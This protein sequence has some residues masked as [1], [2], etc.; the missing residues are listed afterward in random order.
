MPQLYT[1]QRLFGQPGMFLT[2]LFDPPFI[3]GVA[4]I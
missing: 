4:T 2:V 1:P 3:V